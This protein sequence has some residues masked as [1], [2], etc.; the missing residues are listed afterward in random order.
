M[1]TIIQVLPI[2]YASIITSPGGEIMR[3]TT[4]KDCKAQYEN[5]D[6]RASIQRS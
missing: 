6:L 4:A 3:H 2:A 1:N 5:N